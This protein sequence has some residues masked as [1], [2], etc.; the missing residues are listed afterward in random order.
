MDASVLIVL[1]K[2]VYGIGKAVYDLYKTL[3]KNRIFE[4]FCTVVIG[5]TM[6][7]GDFPLHA[8]FVNNIEK[9]EKIE[10]S[11]T[12]KSIS[13]NT[14]ALI[15]TGTSDMYKFK[16]YMK[17][18]KKREPDLN[19]KM[20]KELSKHIST[21]FWSNTNATYN[22]LLKNGINPKNVFV[23]YS[24]KKRDLPKIPNSN[25][26][27]KNEINK[28]YSNKTTKKNIQNILEKINTKMRTDNYED[29]KLM[30]ILS[31]EGYMDPDT[32]NSYAMI[33]NTKK[34]TPEELSDYLKPIN[35]TTFLIVDACNAG[36]FSEIFNGN[37]K[38][39]SSTASIKN[40]V[41][42]HTKDNSYMKIAT[43]NLENLTDIDKYM[44]Y[45]QEAGAEYSIFAKDEIQKSNIKL[46]K[47]SII[48]TTYSW[49]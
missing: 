49:Q 4:I 17:N 43:K 44:T 8:T 18:L 45:I 40:S 32:D 34:I 41:G 39:F 3:W 33:D 48:G 30:L 7:T 29:S 11:E 5:L 36:G 47:P 12:L 13:N 31:T 15:I 6:Q 42:I 24:G 37:K 28:K 26:I 9:I 1:F 23:L 35:G 21:N 25:K 27:L 46:Y 19:R 38:I 16:S 2:L 10:L 20:E 14:Y 22:N